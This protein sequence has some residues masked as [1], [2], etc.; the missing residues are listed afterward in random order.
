MDLISTLTDREGPFYLHLVA[1]LAADIE[2]KGPL[3]GQ[4]L[5]THRSHYG[6]PD[7]YGSSASR[8]DAGSQR[9]GHVRRRKP[10][11]PDTLRGPRAGFDL[12]MILPPQP[13]G[14][15]L[16]R[17]TH[18]LTAPARDWAIRASHLPGCW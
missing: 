13:P 8:A 15:D 1:A 4:Q 2:I 6:D 3:S 10:I 14:S 9:A 17:L 5:L 11:V 7:L 18:E 12:S 16:G